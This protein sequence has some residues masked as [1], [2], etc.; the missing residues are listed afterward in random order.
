VC[1]AQTLLPPPPVAPRSGE[2]AAQLF[3]FAWYGLLTAQLPTWTERVAW[4]VL[5]H[6]SD[7]VLYLQVRHAAACARRFCAHPMGC[8]WWW[9]WILP[10]IALSHASDFVLYLQVRHAAACMSTSAHPVRHG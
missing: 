7:F 5:S 9:L 6:A 4:I 3:F 8:G 1:L 10:M 2:F